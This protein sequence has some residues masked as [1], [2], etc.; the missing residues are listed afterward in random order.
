[1]QIS[2]NYASEWPEL[3]DIWLMRLALETG[4]EV[5]PQEDAEWLVV[6]AAAGC[7]PR[8]CAALCHLI[9]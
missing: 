2:N 4:C 5:T 6:I 9:S 7:T 8:E 1:V 3:Q